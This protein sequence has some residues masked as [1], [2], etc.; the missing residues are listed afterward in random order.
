M[1]NDSAIELS[2]CSL[3]NVDIVETSLASEEADVAVVRVWTVE[4]WYSSSFS[5]SLL[6]IFLPLIST[7]T[8][9]LR[10]KT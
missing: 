5:I 8:L 2:Q 4:E 7:L 3:E 9:Q 10:T 6:L 1:T